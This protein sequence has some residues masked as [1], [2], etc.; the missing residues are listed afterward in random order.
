MTAVAHLCK[1]IVGEARL[2]GQQA[3]CER[4][5]VSRSAEGSGEL[6]LLARERLD[7]DREGLLPKNPVHRRDHRISRDAQDPLALRRV[8]AFHCGAV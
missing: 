5:V 7:S 3:D 2:A 1:V 8:V 6:D 4:K